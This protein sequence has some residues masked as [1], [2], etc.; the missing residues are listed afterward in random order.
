M[1]IT[2]RTFVKTSAAAATGLV[3]AVKLPSFASGNA[4]PGFAPNAY[5]QITPDNVVRLWVTRSEMGQGVRTTLP[6]ML[7]EELD[8]DWQQVQLAQASTSE[9]FKGIRLRTSG[10]GSTVGTYAALRKAGATAREMLVAAAAESWQVQPATCAAK[11]GSVSHLPT[12]RR[13][14]YGQ[15]ASSAARQEVPK[16]PTLKS[17]KDFLLIGKPRKRTDGAAIVA[18]RAMFGIDTRIPGMLYAVMERCPVL[19]G[20]PASYDASKALALKGVRY[21]APIK[22]G[23]SPG[24]A[25][26]AD[27]TWSALKGREALK[28]EW[29][30]GPHRNFSSAQFV[31]ELHA[32]LAQDGY[33]VRNDGDAPAAIRSAVNTLEATYEF[34]YQAH[35]PLET[36]NCVADVRKDACEIW[37]P[38]QCP[39]EARNEAAQMLGLP[40]EAVTVHVTL[41]GG[42]F[43]R[44]LFSDYVHQTVELSREIGKPVQLLWT[45]SDDMRFGYFQPPSVER[46]TG[47]WDAEHK[48]VAWL[49]KSAGCDLSMIPSTDAELKN[50]RRYFENEEPWGSF[51]NPYNFPH[52]KADFVPLDSPVPTGPWRAVMYPARVFAR[53]S[54]LDEMAAKANQDPLAFRLRLLAPGDVLKIGGQKIDRSRLIRVLQVAAEKS[55]WSRPISQSG[56]RLWGRGIA[57]NVYDADC[58]IAQVA[59]VSVG[60]TSHDIRVHRIVCVVDCGLVIN[61]QGLDGQAESGITWGLSATLHGGIDFRN[62]GALQTSYADFRVISIDEA[63]AIETHIVDSG[64]P[65]AGFGETAV[66]PVAPAVANAIFAATG[67][68]MRQLPI[69]PEKL[70]SA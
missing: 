8:A 20:K 15:L 50:P 25:V 55:D 59:E 69:T 31:D 57:C 66:P 32:A 48:P 46:I 40:P 64:H 67:K 26:V 56:D 37:V 19:G 44:R 22:S 45:R 28:M 29:D 33:F 9:Q 4:A 63:P 3:I 11:Q 47:A 58:F 60:K 7:A 61:P 24:V 16:N 17:P 51:D 13:L 52:L 5:I 42:G 35:A 27:N 53:E 36:M 49:Q 43:G 39:N 70:K 12:G 1:T 21:V 68:R 34:P 23:L 6:M 18:G 62:G 2:R 41:L 30:L 38:S 65:P 14:T 10:S 54:F